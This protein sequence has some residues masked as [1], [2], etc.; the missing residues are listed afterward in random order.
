MS[1]AFGSRTR[2]ARTDLGS[3]AH[4]QFRVDYEHRQTRTSYG[5]DGWSVPAL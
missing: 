2:P 1:D 4:G 3:F 5:S